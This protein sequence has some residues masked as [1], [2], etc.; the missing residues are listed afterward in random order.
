MTVPGRT[1]IGQAR[2]NALPSYLV[3]RVVAERDRME[4]NPTTSDNFGTRCMCIIAE[5]TELV[6]AMGSRDRRE[7]AHELADVTMYLVVMLHDLLDGEM[8]PLRAVYP[9]EAPSPFQTPHA[10]IGPTQRAVVMAFEKWRRNNMGDAVMSLQIAMLEVC[11]LSHTLDMSL[12]S[13]VEDKVEILRQRQP[14]NG[15]KRADT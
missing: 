7:I 15:G 3:E 13:V 4:W 8:Y 10:L 12:A 14:L 6:G 5:L 11:R 2:V 9:R 1:I